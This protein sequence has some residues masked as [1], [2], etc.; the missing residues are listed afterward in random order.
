MLVTICTD[1]INLLS[2]RTTLRD[3]KENC[4]TLKVVDFWELRP[5]DGSKSPYKGCLS[6]SPKYKMNNYLFS[7]FSEIF[8]DFGRLLNMWILVNLDLTT[9]LHIY[10]RAE[11]IPD[12][13]R[14]LRY[15]AYL[16]GLPTYPSYLT[17][18]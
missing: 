17:L 18:H 10:R 8:S 16:P 5:S 11:F 9:T 4:L 1:T 12:S 7:I 6:F 15:L 13:S 3:S 2:T 14:R